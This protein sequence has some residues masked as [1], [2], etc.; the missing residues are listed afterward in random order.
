VQVAGARKGA[1][2]G[3]G[4]AGA[5]PLAQQRGVLLPARGSGVSGGAGA[6]GGGARS[7]P[8]APLSQ[9]AVSPP[10][11]PR[12]DSLPPVGHHRDAGTCLLIFIFD[13]K[14]YIIKCALL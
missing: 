3:S 7:A 2:L 6:A 12:A 9:P 14:L 5:G 4:R 11:Q 1:G 13:R 8:P 10:P